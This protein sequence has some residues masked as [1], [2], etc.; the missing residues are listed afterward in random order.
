MKL[1]YNWLIF[2]FFLLTFG[3]G[4]QT[5]FLYFFLMVVNSEGANI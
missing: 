5:D 2:S 4:T 3:E 1:T